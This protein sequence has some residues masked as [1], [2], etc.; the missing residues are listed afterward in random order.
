MDS[1]DCSPAL[2][3]KTEA[4]FPGV[5]SDHKHASCM[6]RVDE[7]RGGLR[8]P[9]SRA[10]LFSTSNLHSDPLLMSFHV[11]IRDQKRVLGR[12][13][14]RWSSERKNCSIDHLLGKQSFSLLLPSPC[15]LFSLSH[16][17]IPFMPGDEE[18]G[19]GR[20]RERRAGKVHHTRRQ[21]DTEAAY[22]RGSCM[23]RRAVIEV[24]AKL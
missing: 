2:P 21:S 24:A 3:A 16:L 8:F 19:D 14:K 11:R 12:K 17:L 22:R 10:L 1:I 9:A 18:A 5:I 4:R 13:N 7:E 23:D 6:L 15:S 20:E